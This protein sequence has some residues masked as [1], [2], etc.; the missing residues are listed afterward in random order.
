MPE[1]LSNSVQRAIPDK[2]NEW[3]RMFRGGMRR[4]VTVGEVPVRFDD[5]R[6]FLRVNE[7]KKKRTGN[8]SPPLLP[9]D[10]M[11]GERGPS[12][13]RGNIWKVSRRVRGRREFRIAPCR[14][15]FPALEH[16][17]RILRNG[18]DRNIS[19]GVEMCN[20]V[21]RT[22]RDTIKK[23]ERRYNPNG[24]PSEPSSVVALTPLLPRQLVPGHNRGFRQDLYR[25]KPA[26]SL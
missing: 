20:F 24:R 26:I 15:V 5:S 6:A 16:V 10:R 19:R 9:M 13:V 8:C 2:Y 12:P 7:Y 11:I 18:R 25:R 17:K 4:R 3:F 1:L 21:P 23:Q 22:L 14:R